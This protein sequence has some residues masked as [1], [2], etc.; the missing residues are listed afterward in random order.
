MKFRSEFPEEDAENW[1]W[2]SKHRID[3]KTGRILPDPEGEEVEC[4]PETKTLRRI[5]GG[6]GTGV[7][8]VVHGGQAARDAGQGWLS[9]NRLW[10]LAGVL[11]IYFMLARIY[12]DAQGL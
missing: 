12:G 8:A 7:G 6:S 5:L 3:P 9:K 11:L 2:I 10:T 1:T 4:S